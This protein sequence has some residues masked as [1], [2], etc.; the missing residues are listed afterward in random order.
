VN[1]DALFKMLLKTPVIL[2]GFFDAFL[3][4]AGQF[5]DFN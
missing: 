2:R 5:V 4:E 1:H 3:P